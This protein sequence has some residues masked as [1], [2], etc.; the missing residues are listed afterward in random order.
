MCIICRKRYKQHELLR[1]QKHEDIVKFSQSGRSFYLCEACLQKENIDTVM[2]K[3]FKLE[4]ESQFFNIKKEF[5]SD[6]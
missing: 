3:R 1:L 5:L 4:K 2:T 6:G